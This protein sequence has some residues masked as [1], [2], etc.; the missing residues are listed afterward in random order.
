MWRIKGVRHMLLHRPDFLV[1]ALLLFN[2]QNIQRHCITGSL[3][4]CLVFYNVAKY[5]Q[6]CQAH[7]MIIKKLP[8][9]RMQTKR[10]L[11]LKYVL[12]I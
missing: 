12:G 6:C 9:P 10:K 1:S 3:R 4:N 11:L 5:I 8:D 2:F 7:T